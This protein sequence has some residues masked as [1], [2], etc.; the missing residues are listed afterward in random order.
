MNQRTAAPGMTRTAVAA[1]AV[2]TRA[3]LLTRADIPILGKEQKDTPAKND[4]GTPETPSDMVGAHHEEEE[5]RGI[6]GA[7]GE[8]LG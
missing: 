6:S 2:R 7:V 8:L 4:T 1:R 5:E 3:G